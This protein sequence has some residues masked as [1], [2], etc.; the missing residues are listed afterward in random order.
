[1]NIYF[2]FY[3]FFL[4][5]SFNSRDLEHKN[6]IVISRVN[7]VIPCYFI[8]NKIYGRTFFFFFLLRENNKNG[9]I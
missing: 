3:M 7:T 8:K 5:K 4:I 1:M 2:I 9:K 6:N